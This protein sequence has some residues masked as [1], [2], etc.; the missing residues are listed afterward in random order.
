[1]RSGSARIASMLVL[2]SYPYCI[3]AVNRPEAPHRRQGCA[4]ASTARQHSKGGRAGAHICPA[5]LRHSTLSEAGSERRNWALSSGSEVLMNMPVPISK[6]AERV[7]RGTTATYQCRYVES[8]SRS[9][10][11]R[12]T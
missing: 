5:H 7:T 3:T 2:L 1:M 9:G 4:E 12:I 8:V 11:E 10:E 6:P